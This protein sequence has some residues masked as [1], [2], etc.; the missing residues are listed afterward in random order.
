M[1]KHA[2]NLYRFPQKHLLVS[3]PLTLFIG[4][5]TGSLIDTSFLKP[6]I[7]YATIVMI[8]ATVIGLD[9]KELSTLKRPKVLI[10]SFI[11]NFVLIPLVA[12]GIGMLFLQNRPMMFAGLALS[13]LLPTSGMTISWTMLQKGNISAAVKLTV[14]G[15]MIGSLLTPWYLLAM[16]GQFVDIHILETIRTILLIVF[17]PIIL[18]Q[19]T[20]KLI[21]QKYTKAQ[22]KK[23]VKPQFAPLSV[24][25]MLYV[26]F[27]SISMR[28]SMML[29][30]LQLIVLALLVLVLFYGV[31]YVISTLFAVKWLNRGDGIALVNGTVLR[32][33]SIAIGLAATSFGAE[34]ALIVTLAF[35]VQQQSITYY[36]RISEERWFKKT[37][38]PVV[39]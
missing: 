18:G 26:V 30:N 33:L 35:I 38:Q 15:L 23:R 21:L 10:L 2:L 12:Y 1:R 36:A 31:N 17:V 32:N 20:Y 25:G 4:F 6:T 3:V 19:I 37:V 27:A 16:V 22:F 39:K 5:I 7:L 9:F 13:A 28:A 34:A 29:N 8:Y 14:L 24:W 11:I